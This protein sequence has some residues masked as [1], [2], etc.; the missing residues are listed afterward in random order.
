MNNVI[1]HA[2]ASSI[3][4]TVDDR[5]GHLHLTVRDDGVGG[6]DAGGPGLTGIVTRVTA[7]GGD[8]RLSSPPG[9]PTTIDVEI[10]CG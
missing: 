5:G 8:L 3:G 9:G 4:I 7:A 2:G 10:P 6:A 1:E